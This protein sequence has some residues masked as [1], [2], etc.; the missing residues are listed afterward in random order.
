MSQR[1]SDF[2]VSFALEF[3][4]CT[5]LAAI[6]VDHSTTSTRRRSFGDSELCN[7][8]EAAHATPKMNVFE[9]FCVKLLTPASFK[10]PLLSCGWWCFFSFYLSCWH[11]AAKHDDDKDG[12][13]DDYD[14]GDGDGGDDD[15]DGDEAH[16]GITA[17]SFCCFLRAG[18][19]RGVGQGLMTFCASGYTM[20]AL[21]REVVD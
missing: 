8:V 11:A 14:D 12:G 21:R 5:L 17:P 18:W 10:L 1:V 19:W 3:L 4:A 13:G 20:R 2:D 7:G 9:A 16:G 15:D 6:E